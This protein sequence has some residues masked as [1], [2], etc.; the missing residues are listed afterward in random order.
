MLTLSSRPTSNKRPSIRLQYKLLSFINSFFDV[1]RIVTTSTFK[2][3]DNIFNLSMP[4]LPSYP[5]ANRRRAYSI[6]SPPRPRHR[7]TY[8]YLISTGFLVASITSNPRSLSGTSMPIIAIVVVPSSYFIH[9]SSPDSWCGP[10]D[11]KRANAEASR[12][13]VALGDHEP[14][15]DQVCCSSA[16]KSRYSIKP[17]WFV[18]NSGRHAESKILKIAGF[19]DM[20]NYALFSQKAWYYFFRCSNIIARSFFVASVWLTD[21]GIIQDSFQCI[22]W[23]LIIW[24]LWTL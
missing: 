14:V 6:L 8:S 18:C 20:Y 24:P 12:L 16:L 22:C 15:V 11:F 5:A 19:P 7:F 21:G 13:N 1:I 4:F 10:G 2:S 3:T 23:Y 17:R 9:G